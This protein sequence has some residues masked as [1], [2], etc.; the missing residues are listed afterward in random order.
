MRARVQ[1]TLLFFLVSLALENCSRARSSAAL[2]LS[3]MMCT[4]DT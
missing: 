3:Q 1:S 2:G 4:R